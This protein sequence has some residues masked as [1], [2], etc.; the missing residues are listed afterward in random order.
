M[1]ACNV[2]SKAGASDISVFIVGHCE[3][4]APKA[5]E[6]IAARIAAGDTKAPQI[7]ADAKGSY[8][9]LAIDDKPWYSGGESWRACGAKCIQEVRR[10]GYKTAQVFIDGVEADR[11]SFVE[12]VYLGDYKF[13]DCRSGKAAKRTAITLRL[14]GAAADVRAGKQAAEAQNHARYVADLPGNLMA[15]TNFI[16]Y[17]KKIF[18]DLP[19]TIKTIEGI[20]ALKKAN[21]PGLVQV[22]QGSVNAP[23]LLQVTYKPKKA[24]KGVHLG[25][26]GKGITFDTGGI[27]LKPGADMWKMKGDMGGAAAML[28]AMHLIA[29]QKLGVAV[30]AIFALAENMPDGKAQRPGDIYETRQGLFVHVDNTDAEGRLVLADALTYACEQKV[31]HLVDAA[32]L[33]GA[34]LVALGDNIAAVMSR[35]DEF[36]QDVRQAGQDVGEEF[37]Q[38]PLYGAYRAKLDHVHADINN[39]GGR[40]VA[41]SPLVFSSANLWMKTCS[42]RIV[43]SQAQP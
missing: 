11:A 37:W 23:A 43:I 13:T 28:G 42:G 38:L 12:G 3:Q 1:H 17:A 15:P 2:V 19:V 29:T 22:G 25:L 34:C 7:V 14:T 35:H 24:K 16:K 30:T 20:P 39:I 41:R 26:V 10:L 21:F 31:T 4:S 9:L 32:T 18:A 27:S 40:L 33:T 8:L 36:A 5:V 6:Q